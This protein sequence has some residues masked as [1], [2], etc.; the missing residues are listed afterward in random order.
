M[1]AVLLCYTM[2]CEWLSTCYSGL[3]IFTVESSV[4]HVVLRIA[5]SVLEIGGL[6]KHPSSGLR[7]LWS[8]KRN[9]CPSSHGRQEGNGVSR[10][11]WPGDTYVHVGE[12]RDHD[13]ETKKWIAE[14]FGQGKVAEKMQL[15][16]RAL[17]MKL[18]PSPWELEKRNTLLDV[19]W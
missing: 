15:L 1:F 16:Q 12:H 6:V 4:L 8:W 14:G 7:S 13:T 18:L 5:L 2:L 10:C 11:Q 3:M 19:Q 17:Y 9:D